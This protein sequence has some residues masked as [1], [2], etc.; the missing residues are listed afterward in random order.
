MKFDVQKYL[1]TSTIHGLVY[2]SKKFHAIER[3]FW[4]IVLLCSTIYTSDLIIEFVVKIIKSPIV[5]YLSDQSIG[6]SEINFPAVTV[7]PQ[8]S[9]SI[10]RGPYS[11]QSKPYYYEKHTL[12]KSYYE[13]EEEQQEFV[14]ERK[15]SSYDY[16]KFLDKLENGSIKP[17]DLGIRLLKRLQV[18]DILENREVFLKLNFSVPAHDFLEISN[19]FLKGSLSF[20]FYWIDEKRQYVTEIVT[21]WGLCFTYNIGFSHDVLHI[22]STSDDFHFQASSKEDIMPSYQSTYLYETPPK[23]L[24]QTIS[25]S[26]AGLWVGISLAYADKDRIAKNTF[27]AYTVLLHDPFELPS[28]NSKIIQLNVKYQTTIQVNPQQNSIDESL[29]DYEPVERNCF[30]ENE[31]VLKFFKVYTKNNCENECLTDFMLSRCG[32]VEFFMIRNSSTRICS[33][34]EQSCY[35]KAA[36]DFEEQKSFC[37]CFQPCEYINYKFE[38]QEYGFTHLEALLPHLTIGFR[39][40]YKEDVFPRLI[41]KTQFTIVDFLAFV[42]GILGLFAGISILSFVELIYW[43]TVRVIILNV[44][45]IDTKVYSMSR[46]RERVQG[47]TKIKKFTQSYLRQSSIHGLGYISE[48]SWIINILWTFFVLISMTCCIHLILRSHQS[49]PD[50]R[51]IAYDDNFKIIE[52]IPFPAFTI[53]PQFSITNKLANAAFK[54]SWDG[55]KIMRKMNQETFLK[56][57]KDLTQY[58]FCEESF[59]IY[60]LRFNFSFI[61]HLITVLKEQSNVGWFQDQFSSFN[62]KYQPDFAEIRTSR[63]MGFTFNMIDADEMFNFDHSDFN[64]TRNITTRSENS[65]QILKSFNYPLKFNRG[66]EIQFSIIITKPPKILLNCIKQSFIIHSSDD[67]PTFYVRMDFMGFEYGTKFDVIVT[68]EIIR[69][70]EYLRSL[71]PSV[72]GC[73]FDKEK[74][75]K[76]FKK[77]S[78]RNCDVECL[79]NITMNRCGCIDINQPFSNQNEMCLNI[80]RSQPTCLSILKRDLYT[81]FDFSPE[82]NCSCLPLCNSISYNIK[83]YTK[84]ESGGNET[85]INVRMNMDDIV[86]FRRY[87]Q[88]TFSDVVSYVGGLLG[89]FAGISMLSIVEF[90]YFFTI[91]LGVNLWRVLRGG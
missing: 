30:M 88:F 83:Y 17:E 37:E 8:L 91:R 5:S 41:R 51:V 46:V 74:S 42:G 36:E 10:P 13:F 16:G 11:K 66:D 52:S 34:N 7:C 32:C 59:N 2:I 86:L 55:P 64:Y 21:Q 89:L 57:K 35:K 84:H 4:I 38:K 27:K 22:N 60:S 58:N 63:G 61:P 1:E 50:S 76:F 70:E 39:L 12:K 56:L 3:I 53:V 85:T 48:F 49:V 54:A 33:A 78:Q 62:G 68:P 44:K 65:T 9:F 69:T 47:L 87:Q 40:Q 77:Y 31:K 79:A 18:I 24:P 19:E 25:T 28:A 82:Q 75:L 43:F 90:F 73:Y 23:D 26:K 15:L 67:L 72:R 80:S 29:M 6:V 71:K 20:V 14:D 81:F 45:R